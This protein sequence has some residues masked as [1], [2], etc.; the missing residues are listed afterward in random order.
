MLDNKRHGAH[1][2]ASFLF[3]S[4]VLTTQKTANNQLCETNQYVNRYYY[5]ERFRICGFAA[6]VSYF[7]DGKQ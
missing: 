4:I 6:I 2:P 7:T 5:W 1:Y 3:W